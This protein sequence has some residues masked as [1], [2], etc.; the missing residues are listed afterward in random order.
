VTWAPTVGKVVG[1]GH[2]EAGV[3]EGDSVEV[4][5]AMGDAKGMV[6]ATVVP[7]PFLQIRRAS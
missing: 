2:L 1:F 4:E 5:W 6:P 7:L 3:H